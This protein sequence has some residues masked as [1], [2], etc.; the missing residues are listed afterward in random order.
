MVTFVWER[1]SSAAPVA[2]SVRPITERAGLSSDLVFPLILKSNRVDFNMMQAA[3]P[4][5]R[6]SAQMRRELA[7]CEFP[8]KMV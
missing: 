1:M 8:H 2:F 7:S 3:R 6:L 4:P 5:Y